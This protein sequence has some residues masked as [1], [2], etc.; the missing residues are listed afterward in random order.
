[1]PT[2]SL[3]KDG[4]VQSFNVSPKGNYEGFL[5][6][7]NGER[8]QIN[9][10]QQWAASIAGVAA[11]GT[12]I[13]VE[14]EP[15]E[16]HGHSS[17]PVFQLLTLSNE[18]KERFSLQDSIASGNAHF[19]GKVERLN[20]ALHGEVNGAILDSG[21]FLHLKPHGAAAIDLTVGMNVKGRGLTKP[22]VGGH[23]VIE[24]EE[25]NAI[26]MEKKPRPKKKAGHH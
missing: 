16:V 25:V 15:R 10:P 5:L 24:A 6:D 3:T 9:F 19:S 2:R 13:H 23:R 12:P 18:K 17:H 1:M 21:D 4:I 14:I 22:M 26:Q 7:T 20:F 8:I 11:P